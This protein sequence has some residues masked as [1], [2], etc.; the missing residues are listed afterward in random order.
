MGK[1]RRGCTPSRRAILSASTCQREG[2][3]GKGDEEIIRDIVS[4]GARKGKRIE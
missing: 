3:K 2:S 1:R 4:E